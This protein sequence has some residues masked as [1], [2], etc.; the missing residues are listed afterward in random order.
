MPSGVLEEV[1]GVRDDLQAVQHQKGVGAF[2]HSRA[3]PG[4][5]VACRADS[6][7]GELTFHT[8]TIVETPPF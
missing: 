3:D 6:S 5:V 4:W 7:N 1:Q 2:N 8:I